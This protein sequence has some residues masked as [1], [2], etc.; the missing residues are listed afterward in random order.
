MI[1]CRRTNSDGKDFHILVKA[2]DAELKIRDGDEHAFYAQYNSIDT[3]QHAIVAYVNATPIG[4]GAMKKYSVNT[5]ELK[6][7]FVYEAERGKGIASKIVNE[8]EMW[9]REL[10]YTKCILET[11]VRQPEAIALYKKNGYLRIP[12]FGQYINAIGSVCFEKEL[13]KN[14]G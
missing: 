1:N 13:G 14:S 2:L 7:M 4:C 5:V 6:R 3:I 12:N 11:G 8:L 9:A 10:N